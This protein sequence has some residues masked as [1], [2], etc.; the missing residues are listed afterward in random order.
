[1]AAAACRQ[2]KQVENEH[3]KYDVG[4]EIA[5][6]LMKNVDY[7]KT[8]TRQKVIGEIKSILHEAIIAHAGLNKFHE[9][10]TF[11]YIWTES[12]LQDQ[13]FHITAAAWYT[14]YIKH[15]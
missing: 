11:Y 7:S 3:N 12:I 6:M 8:A 1:M 14:Q 4:L 13:H 15:L 2:Y 5:S 10:Y 9:M